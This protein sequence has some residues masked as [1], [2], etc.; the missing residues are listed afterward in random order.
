MSVVNILR[1][2]FAVFYTITVALVS[3]QATHILVWKAN[4]LA[5][6]TWTQLTLE[7]W[8]GSLPQPTRP[9]HVEK[10]TKELAEAI[11]FSQSAGNAWV[12]CKTILDKSSEDCNFSL[13]VI[14]ADVRYN[15]IWSSAIASGAALAPLAA[16]GMLYVVVL[17]LEAA[18]RSMARWWRSDAPPQ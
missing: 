7:L 4:E 15:V 11:T 3:I 1:T 18:N 13:T 5:R 16:F 12:L 8:H 17:G 6:I 2:V 9:C 14:S 10:A